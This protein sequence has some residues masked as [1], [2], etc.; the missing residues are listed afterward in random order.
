MVNQIFAN[1]TFFTT[2]EQNAVGQNDGHNTIITD[3]VQV[4]QQKSIV[5][6]ALGR[7]TVIRKAR[8][9]I[10]VGRIPRLRI[11]GI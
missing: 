8:I 4:V 2:T 3:V 7:K 9:I 11:W 5:R 1:R 10:F 6:L